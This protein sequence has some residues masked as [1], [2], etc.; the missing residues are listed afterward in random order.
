MTGVEK[1]EIKMD[2]R[3]IITRRIIAR[4]IFS[5]FNISMTLYLMVILSQTIK[6]KYY[7]TKLKNEVL[8]QTIKNDVLSHKVKKS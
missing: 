1:S 7:R 2:P 3:R 4:K 5:F 6:T 8:S